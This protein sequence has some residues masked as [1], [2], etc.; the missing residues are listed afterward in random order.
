LFGNPPPLS[1]SLTKGGG[2]SYVREAKPL[3]DS[4]CCGGA[5]R[6]FWRGIAPLKKS[7]SPFI[8]G[9]GIKGIGLIK[10]RYSSALTTYKLTN[11][12]KQ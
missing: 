3:F 1:P 2:I 5:I 10:K 4:P 12:I 6:E 11:R 8:K 7:F 9:K